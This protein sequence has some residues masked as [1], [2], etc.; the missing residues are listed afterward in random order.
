MKGI[1]F[2]EF[3]EMVEEHFSPETADKIISSSNLS[4]AGAYTTVGTYD[5][6]EIIE[7][8]G[9]LSKTTGLQ[10]PELLRAFGAR[11]FKRFSELYPSHFAALHSTFDFLRILD[12]KIHIEVKKLYP[13]AELPSFQHDFPEPDRMIL[14]YNSRRPFADLAEGLIGG[15]IDH[16]RETI[17]LAREDLLCADGTRVR[18]TLTRQFHG[19]PH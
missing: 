9:H 5:H 11:L 12:S 6:R 4:T 2:R 19:Q 13:D 15:C 18:F 14:V 7:L 1:V 17:A 10:P 8:V 16:F 3:I